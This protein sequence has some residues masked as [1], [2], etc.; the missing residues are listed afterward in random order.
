MNTCAIQK[1]QD[2]V[3]RRF[4]K[5]QEKSNTRAAKHSQE[6][7]GYVSEANRGHN[8]H[9]KDNKSYPTTRKYHK[10]ITQMLTVFYTPNRF[11]YARFLSLFTPTDKTQPR[12]QN[13]TWIQTTQCVNNRHRGDDPQE[14][15][16]V[17]PRP[18]TT[19][20]SCPSAGSHHIS[21]P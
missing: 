21:I 6:H 7:I 1:N 15:T 20:S 10:T 12:R 19:P 3:T 17:I 18:N 13:T 2:N 5:K 4:F 8:S 9:D 11:P 14:N 16:A